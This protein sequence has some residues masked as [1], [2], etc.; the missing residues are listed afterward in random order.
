MWP[1]L[2]ASHTRCLLMPHMRSVLL[3]P[4]QL[5]PRPRPRPNF[6][7]PPAGAGNILGMDTKFTLSNSL[8][9]QGFGNFAGGIHL[10]SAGKYSEYLIQVRRFGISIWRQLLVAD[11][12]GGSRWGQAL[13]GQ[14]EGARRQ[15]AGALDDCM[16]RGH[17]VQLQRRSAAARINRRCTPCL[18]R[19]F[20][21]RSAP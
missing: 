19:P 11:G 1:W 14:A 8:V 6:G 17:A 7:H 10:S 5:S 20:A 18:P 3:A 9:T 12:Q 16:A 13:P 4:P 2:T 21:C 15:L